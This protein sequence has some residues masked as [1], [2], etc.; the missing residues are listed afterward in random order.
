[1]MNA[2]A[3][4]QLGDA[5]LK[6][7]NQAL[8]EQLATLKGKMQA[9]QQHLASNLGVSP[10]A[11]H[12]PQALSRDLQ[13]TIQATRQAMSGLRQEMKRL[14]QPVYLKRW[15]KAARREMAL[16]HCIDDDFF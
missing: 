16:Q 14:A 8:K 9:L 13:E 1:L 7:Y 3:I 5:H 10:F 6:K 15:I 12:S 11:V 2:Q 4:H